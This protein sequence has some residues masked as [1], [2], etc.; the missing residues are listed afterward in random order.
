MRLYL[1][2]L[3][4][5]AAGINWVQHLLAE[6]PA[7]TRLVAELRADPSFSTERERIDAFKA[8][9]G[10]CRATYFNQKRKLKSLGLTTPSVEI[11]KKV[12]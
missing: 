1:R 11:A 8:Q 9:G 10:G 6:I 2:A 12:A 5:Q 7:K 3:E 4:L